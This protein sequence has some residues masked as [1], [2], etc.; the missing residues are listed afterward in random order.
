MTET[1]PRSCTGC[2]RRGVLIGAAVAAIT[3][4]CARGSAASTS[5]RI[6]LGDI[7]VGAGRV[8][9]EHGLVVTQPT[10]GDIRAFSATCPHQGRRWKTGCRALRPRRSA[11]AQPR[12]SRRSSSM[13]RHR[14]GRVAGCGSC[15]ARM[16]P[17]PR[18]QQRIPLRG[19]PFRSRDCRQSIR[20]A[21]GTEARAASCR[22][23]LR[24]RD[25]SKVRAW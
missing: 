8:Y 5:V 14:C 2:T 25:D 21:A 7:P 4:G 19:R 16:W 12:R 23:K 10:A 18:P 17:P 15:P 1:E 3:V 24:A 20:R 6:P 9:P 11:P 13:C 22:V